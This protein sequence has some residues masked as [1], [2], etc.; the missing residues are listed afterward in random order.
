MV[1]LFRYRVTSDFSTGFKK[2]AETA[3]MGKVVSQFPIVMWLFFWSSVAM[4]LPDGLPAR[5]KPH[6]P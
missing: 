4:P 5:V 2:L 6:I 1:K 3:T